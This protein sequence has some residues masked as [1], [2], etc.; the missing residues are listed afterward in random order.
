M[1]KKWQSMHHSEDEIEQLQKQIKHMVE[2]VITSA[3]KL[4]AE[5]TKI[6]LDIERQ[7][8]N[9]LKDL[10]MPKAR[11]KVAQKKKKTGPTDTSTEVKPYVLPTFPYQTT[12]KGI[13]NIE[14]LFSANQGEELKAL[15]RIAS[16]GEISRIMLALKT[17]LRAADEIPVLVFDELDIGIGS[18]ISKIVGQKLKVLAGEKQVL[19]ITH[20]PQI[21]SMADHHYVVK[22]VI[23][24]NHTNTLVEKI[25]ATQRIKELARM[26][27]GGGLDSIITTK[28]AQ[29][30]IK[31]QANSSPSPQQQL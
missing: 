22:K 30:L 29:E 6:S 21:A 11:F 28:H 10:H 13:D 27:G 20:S 18:D 5:R 4:S 19:C 2:K 14:F 31:I 1:E 16:G 8:K 9:E 3:D 15:S 24:K 17:L 7:I 23:T 25:K 12:V 26:L